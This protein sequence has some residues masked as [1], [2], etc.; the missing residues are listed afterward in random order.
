[1]APQISPRPVRLHYTLN[2]YMRSCFISSNRLSFGIGFPNLMVV[3]NVSHTIRRHNHASA[4]QQFQGVAAIILDVLW[5]FGQD[6]EFSGPV[7]LHL[8]STL[9]IFRPG[10]HA[11]TI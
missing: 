7:A 3:L 11:V 4:V 5:H 2:M 9:L 1:M 6:Q 10:S 8:V